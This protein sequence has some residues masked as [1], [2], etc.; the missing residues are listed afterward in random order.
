MGTTVTT[1]LEETVPLVPG[2]KLLPP[3][4][5]AILTSGEGLF[6]A[7]V[8]VIVTFVAEVIEGAVNSPASEIVPVL[9][10]Q[11]T[12]VLL[13]DVK[14]AT[15]C[16]LAP[17]EMIAAEGETMSLIFELFGTDEDPG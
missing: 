12:A 11:T 3:P 5:R 16:C 6:P 8:A 7:F 1:A 15:N 2:A 9:A 10:V 4:N 17:E 14:V 13:V